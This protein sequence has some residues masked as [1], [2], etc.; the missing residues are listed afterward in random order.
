MS[1]VFVEG[2][3]C[4][5]KQGGLKLVSQIQGTLS[6]DALEKKNGLVFL[7]IYLNYLP[8]LFLPPFPKGAVGIIK[9]Y[10]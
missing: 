10:V 2:S 8:H 3:V 1:T 7:P 6:R 9:V 4:E 5:F